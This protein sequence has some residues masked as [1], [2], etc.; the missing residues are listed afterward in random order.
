MTINITDTAFLIFAIAIISFAVYSIILLITNVY[1]QISAKDIA[2]F[3]LS[4]FIFGFLIS[5]YIDANAPD[6]LFSSVLLVIVV[7]YF[8]YKSIKKKL[9]D[10]K[11]QEV[12]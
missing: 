8:T 3:S 6:I 12:M 2:L 11:A 1:V 5:S 4:T 10:K 9:T 7:F